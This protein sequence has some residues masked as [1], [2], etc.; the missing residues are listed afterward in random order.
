MKPERWEEVRRLFERAQE[1]PAAEREAFVRREAGADA[2]LATE[3]LRMLAAEDSP[4]FIE[5]PEIG[6]DPPQRTDLP[7]NLGDLELL[8]EIGR[9]GMGIVY[10]AR[11]RSLD[12]IVAVKELP[13]TWAANPT[14]RALPILEA[15]AGD[16]P[17]SVPL[18]ANARP[19]VLDVR[20]ARRRG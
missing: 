7:R 8:E 5:P 18:S 14:A 15:L 1:I 17:A 19:F 13:V 11:Q 4:G 12:R 20:P 9:G 2:E 10:R 16:A 6:P 3:V